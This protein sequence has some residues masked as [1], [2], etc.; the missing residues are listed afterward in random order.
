MCITK[1][2]RRSR[3]SLNVGRLTALKWLDWCALQHRQLLLLWNLPYGINEDNKTFTCCNAVMNWTRRVLMLC[4]YDGRRKLFKS[5]ACL[6]IFNKHKLWRHGMVNG[7][8]SLPV[9]FRRT[10]YCWEQNYTLI[11]NIHVIQQVLSREK[12]RERRKIG[13]LKIKKTEVK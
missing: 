4:Q 10:S 2:S 3:R 5:S 13:F 7:L 12:Q 8:Q 1:E 9:P 11:L 6:L